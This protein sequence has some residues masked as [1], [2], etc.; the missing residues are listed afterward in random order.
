MREINRL[1]PKDPANDDTAARHRELVKNIAKRLR[2]VCA[3]MPDSEFDAMVQRLADLELK[4]AN[5][6]TPSRRA[7]DAD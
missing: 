6:S 1:S 2:P 7:T 4:Y 3:N 5:R